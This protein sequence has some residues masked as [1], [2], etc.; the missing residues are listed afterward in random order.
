MKNVLSPNS[1][2]T[3]VEI[4]ETNALAGPFAWS[5]YPPRDVELLL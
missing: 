3:I 5:G 2:T 4:E 1:E